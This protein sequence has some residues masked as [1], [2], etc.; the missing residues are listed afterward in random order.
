VIEAASGWRLRD[1]YAARVE[2]ALQSLRPDGF[3]A[4]VGLVLGSGLGTVV[5]RMDVAAER[6]FDTIPGFHAP[7]VMAHAGRLVQAEHAGR[8][9]L[10]LQGRLHAYE[11]LP[12]AD[13]VF[14][15]A[16]LLGLGCR[17]LLLTNAAGGLHPDARAG[18][19]MALTGLIDLHL[20]DAGRG[21][22]LPPAGVDPELALRAAT[23]LPPFDRDLAYRLVDVGAAAGIPVRTGVYASLWG[24]NY[25]P[26]VEIGV[27]REMGCDAVG[28]STGPETAF[29]VRMGA[30][31]GGISCITNVA[32]EHGGD[33][34]THDEVVEV[35]AAVRDALTHLIL[36]FLADG[37]DSEGPTD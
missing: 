37:D 36:A 27:L 30:K 20:A 23:H 16:T 1:D 13:V 28:M 2:E 8:A 15:V 12:L 26:A 31:V 17:T 29:A 32:V 33:V 10:I 3:G 19:L 9:A 5:D 34:V 35:G 7:S 14:P 22:V 6:S 4:P 11:G 25:E 18:D 24:P 21:L